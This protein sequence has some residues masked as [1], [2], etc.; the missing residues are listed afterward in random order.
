MGARHVPAHQINEHPLELLD[1]PD[2]LPEDEFD[3]MKRY[4][5][6]GASGLQRTP[7]MPAFARIVAF[8]LHLKQD[9]S[10]CPDKL[11]PRKLN[12]R[13]MVN[14]PVVKPFENLPAGRHPVSHA[15]RL[16]TGGFVGPLTYLNGR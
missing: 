16:D 11:D 8:E 13:M 9:L 10:G 5:V 3:T 7:E 1:K 12:L 6:D 4:L 2:K 14:Q 15:V